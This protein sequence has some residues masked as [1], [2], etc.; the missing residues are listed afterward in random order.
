MQGLILYMHY[1]HAKQVAMMNVALAECTNLGGMEGAWRAQKCPLA[2]TSCFLQRSARS[3]STGFSRARAFEGSATADGPCGAS[4][5]A[6]LGTV[7]SWGMHRLRF[8]H[9]RAPSDARQSGVKRHTLIPARA[10]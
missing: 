5:L 7:A 9:C 1:R 2:S 10:R 4:A 8:L 3:A 6:A